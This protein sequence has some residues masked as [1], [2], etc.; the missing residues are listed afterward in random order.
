LLETGK[1]RTPRAAAIQIVR[2]LKLRQDDATAESIADRLRKRFKKLEPE[3]R[4]KARQF[5]AERNRPRPGPP[6]PSLPV[7]SWYPGMKL[8]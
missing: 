3:L 2:L 7:S 4:E 5:I 6:P 8:G 1:A